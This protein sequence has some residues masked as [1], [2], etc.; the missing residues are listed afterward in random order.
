MSQTLRPQEQGRQQDMGRQKLALISSGASG[1]GR[2]VAVGFAKEGTDLALYLD[3][4]SQFYLTRAVL[5]HM[6]DGG[7]IINTTSVTAYQGNPVLLDYASTKGA[8]IGL[9]RSLS[10]QL[11]QRGKSSRSRADPDTAHPRQLR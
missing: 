2:A 5:P 4:L 7:A 10:K 8:I 3:E 11:V 1:I 6:P 9:T